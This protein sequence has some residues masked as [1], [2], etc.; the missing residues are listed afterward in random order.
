[1]KHLRMGMAALAAMLLLPLAVTAAPRT[2]VI[3]PEHFSIAFS[4]EHAGFAD[5]M[6]LFRRPRDSSFMT[7]RRANS[8]P[9][10]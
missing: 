10:R 5:V 8:N 3:D 1:M 4:V 9:A 7:R 6:G 2:W